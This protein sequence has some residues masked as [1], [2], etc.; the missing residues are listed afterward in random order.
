MRYAIDLPNFGDYGDARLLAGLARET[1]A[2]GWEGFFIWDHI[3]APGTMPVADTTVT[4]AAR[5]REWIG[6]SWCI[7]FSHPKDFTPVCTTKL[8]YTARI[9]PNS[10]SATPRLS[11]SA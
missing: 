1:E 5:L 10:T 6:D 9:S 2:H 7:L 4:L 11:G 3:I 8:G